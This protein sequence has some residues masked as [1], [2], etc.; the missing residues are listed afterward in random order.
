MRKS[1]RFL[2]DTWWSFRIA[3]SDLGNCGLWNQYEFGLALKEVAP[4]KDFKVLVMGTIY[5]TLLDLARRGCQI[6]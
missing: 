2:V 3:G 5:E 1:E 6:V 4:L